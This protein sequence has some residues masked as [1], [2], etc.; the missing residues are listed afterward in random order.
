[1]WSRTQCDAIVV[2][3]LVVGATGMGAHPA[4]A[5]SGALQAGLKP[6]TLVGRYE[7][8][9]VGPDGAAMALFVELK[10]TDGRF[11]GYVD[12][13]AAQVSVLGGSLEGDLLTLTIDA[14]GMAGVMRGKVV[15]RRIDGTWTLGDMAGSFAIEKVGTSGDTVTAS[16]TASDEISGAWLGEAD[17][18]GQ[19]M[20][21]MLTLKLDGET[22][23]GDIESAMGKVP[24]TG[25]QW[26]DGT[27]TLTFPYV[28][29]E[30][31][32]M[33]A[34]LKDGKLQGVVDYN[35]GE[36]QGTWVASKK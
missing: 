26:K 31:V 11:S 25:G 27:L 3:L 24:L 13:Q 30:P 5:Q 4:G 18:Q 19:A 17:V 9:A 33:G 23:S 6:E 8:T 10:Y 2:A 36:L 28:G 21:F 15:D 12:A 20:P 22:V 7:G 35:T 16:S 32:S 34:Q 1:M 29:G 14:G